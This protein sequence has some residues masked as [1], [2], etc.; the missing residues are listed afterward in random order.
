MKK[1][2][3]NQMGL[4]DGGKMFGYSQWCDRCYNGQQLCVTTYIAFWIP[5]RS[6]D[7]MPC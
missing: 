4:I 1:L 7:L 5:F 2:E 3:L 6:T